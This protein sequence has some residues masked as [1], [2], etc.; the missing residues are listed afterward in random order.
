MSTPTALLLLILLFFT[1]LR[2]AFFN[3]LQAAD[4]GLLALLLF[5]VYFWYY[6]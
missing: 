4:A 6:R 2:L 1:D 5:V 3:V